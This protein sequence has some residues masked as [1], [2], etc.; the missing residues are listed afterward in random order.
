MKQQPV[1][2]RIQR[3]SPQWGVSQRWAVG[4]A[5]VLRGLTGGFTF[6]KTLPREFG[7][8]K[9]IVTSRSDIRLLAPGF[10]SS[11]GDLLQIARLCI[12]SG[13]CVWDL[14][15]NLGIFA[16]CAAWKA[17]PNGK[18]FSLEAD[19]F[20]AEFQHRTVKTLPEGYA[21]VVPLCAAVADKMTI[22]DLAVPKRGHSRS[23]LKT[24][25]GNDPGETETIKQ[26][27]SVTCDFLVEHWGRPDFV[28]VDIE[29]AELLFLSGARKLLETM[30]P[31]FYIE[32]SERNRD[33]ATKILRSQDYVL[34]RFSL[35]G[36]EIPLRGCEFNTV[37]KPAEKQGL[38]FL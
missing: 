14:G 30:R 8:A 21:P 36:E 17:G 15:S 26:V 35:S 29:G 3:K 13:D 28:K 38:N 18:V 2:D 20:Y 9:I 24:V 10:T 16:F 7:G 37:A 23:Y 31:T 22:L 4:I 1:N 5:Q 6:R 12:R 11:A 32:V 34:S 33:D 27:V 25:A 19:P